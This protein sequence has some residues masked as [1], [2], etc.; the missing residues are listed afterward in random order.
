MKVK[1][2]FGDKECVIALLNL[3]LLLGEKPKEAKFGE[4]IEVCK[5]TLNLR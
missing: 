3:L 5:E 2:T 4:V 1:V